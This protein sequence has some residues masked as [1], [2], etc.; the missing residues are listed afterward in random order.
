MLVIPT[1]AIISPSVLAAKKIF[2]IVGLIS[3]NQGFCRP[4]AVLSTKR[5]DKAKTSHKQVGNHGFSQAQLTTFVSTPCQ[6]KGFTNCYNRLN[7]SR[8]MAP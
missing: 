3:S 4:I 1:A 7:I 2:E 5:K 6:T 8:K